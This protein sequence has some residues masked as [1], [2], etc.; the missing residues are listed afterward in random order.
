MSYYVDAINLTHLTL[1]PH[2]CVSEPGQHWFRWWLVAYSTV[3]S[4]YLNQCW[5]IVN[6]TL[7]NKP[8]CN[9]NKNSKLFINENASE[10]VVCERG[11]H[12]VQGEMSKEKSSQVNLC[13]SELILRNIKIQTKWPT[14][15]RWPLRNFNKN[16]KLFINENASE[17]VVC[18]RG[19]HFVQGE[20]S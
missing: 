17:D 6:R 15:P 18:E 5:V 11:G 3:L 10:D 13:H 12:F 19:G 14:F 20:M 1:V 8:L 7:R 4:H 16:S 9:F 2:I